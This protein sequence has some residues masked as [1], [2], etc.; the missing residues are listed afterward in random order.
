M[1]ITARIRH[2]LLA[3]RMGAMASPAHVLSV[4]FA[5]LV[6]RVQVA[7]VGADGATPTW[8]QTLRQLLREEGT[9]GLTRGLAPRMVSSALW[10]T[11]MLSTYEWVKRSSVR[12]E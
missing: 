8:A 7:A 3:A 10:G 12:A 5:A 4:V 1:S 9:R 6:C 11:A 2:A